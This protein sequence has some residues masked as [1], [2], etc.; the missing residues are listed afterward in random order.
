[1]TDK[2]PFA[3]CASDGA[4]MREG[5][6]ALSELGSLIAGT[7]VVVLLA[8]SDV[9][10]LSLAIPPMSEAKLKLA[11][12]SLAEEQILG[13]T[14]DN[15]FVLAPLGQ[16]GA[17]STDPRTRR[18][19]AV[20]ERR[21]L[22]QLSTQLFGLGARQV[23]ALP[24]Q[25]CLPWLANVSSVCITQQAPNLSFDIAIRIDVQAGF[26]LTLD[27][28]ATL[29]D[30]LDTLMMVAPIGKIELYLSAE[31]LAQSK[32]II[33]ANS[34]WQE[35]ITLHKISWKDSIANAKKVSI[36]LLS[37]LNN[38]QNNRVQWR[39]WRWT[40]ILAA[41][42]LLINIIGLNAQFWSMKR[43]AQS[44]KTSM[45]QIY[46]TAF[47]KETV[48]PNPLEQMKRHLNEA[49][50]LSGQPSADD[51]TL[52]LSQFGA[53]WSSLPAQQLPKITS[54]EYKDK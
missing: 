1:M 34:A 33:D 4:L 13:D 28:N 20:A 15:V 2:L 23:S 27:S 26:G 17:S 14:A 16:A 24:A 8:A 6:S 10:L 48:I 35:R 11:L 38:A 31:L 29:N 18:S 12:P 54:I 52:L 49:T 45:M 53:A 3:L 32:A 36:N 37:N 30:C 43:E 7:N 21:W 39:A 42:V 44:I 40:L 51:F 25:L 19:I 46:K 22:Q 9:T 47:P 50:R 5:A 41:S